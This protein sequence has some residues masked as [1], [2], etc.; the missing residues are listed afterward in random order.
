MG[1][2]VATRAFKLA[3]I[4]RKVLDDVNVPRAQVFRPASQPLR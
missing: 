3:L 1:V 4:G 2:M